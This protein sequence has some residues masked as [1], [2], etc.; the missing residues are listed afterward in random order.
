MQERTKCLRGEVTVFFALSI[1][2]I[3]ALLLSAAESARVQAA[4]LYLTQAANA[5]IDSLFSQYHEKLWSDYRLLALENYSSRQLEEET[6]SFLQPYLNVKNWYSLN[7][8]AVHLKE[9]RSLTDEEG[10]LFEREVLD[11]MKYGIAAAVMDTDRAGGFLTQMQEAK[12]ADAITGL[13]DH[14][15]RAAVRLEQMIEEIAASLEEQEIQYKEAERTLAAYDGSAFI[16]KAEKMIEALGKLPALVENYQTAADQLGEELSSSREKLEAE[17]AA[18]SLSEETYRYF[19]EDAETYESYTAEDGERRKEIEVLLPRSEADIGFL[20][21]MIEE[22][23]RIQEEIDAW[24][25]EDEEDELDEGALWRPL[26]QELETYDLLKLNVQYGIGD[27]E[28]E[29]WLEGVK[30]LMQTDLLKL[31]LPEGVKLSKD[32]VSSADFPTKTVYGG[33]KNCRLSLADRIYMAEYQIQAMNYYGRDQ[34]WEHAGKKGSGL[35]ET[36]YILNGKNSDYENL[37]QTAET[38]L[39]L[40]TGL[41]LIY[42]YQDAEKRAEARTLALG[43]TGAFGFTPIAGV[44]T[45]FIMG[46]WALGQAGCDVRDLLRGE[47]VP[48][49]HNKKSFYLSLNGLLEIGKAGKLPEELRSE[50]IE[51]MNYPDYLRLFL[52]AAAGT[53][54]DYRCMDMIQKAIQLEQQDF[55]LSRCAV[56]VRE[57][58]TARTAHLFTELLT[59]KTGESAKLRGGYEMRVETSFQYS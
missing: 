21:G 14:H 55:L 58:I 18:G 39:M 10:E 33:S 17:H 12:S 30:N 48:F 40:R 25:P 13:Y 20:E 3:F 42:L 26:I 52:I 59:V 38:L 54:T 1:T 43:I 51:G 53:E 56:S 49:L 57:E 41:N 32:A 34:Y 16:Q 8:P 35:L 29:S 37:R 50:R 44:M 28:K 45:F 11:Y 27:A 31:L 23:K 22:A 19:C 9:K 7:S 15:S 24:E 5:S 6:L 2:M 4:R 36:E 47:S 46:V